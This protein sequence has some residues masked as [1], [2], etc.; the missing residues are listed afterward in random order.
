MFARERAA[1]GGH[2]LSDEELAAL[3]DGDGDDDRE[4]A[5]LK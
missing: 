1:A 3:D 4:G 2:E 5:K